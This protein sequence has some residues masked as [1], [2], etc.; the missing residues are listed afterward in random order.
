MT[1]VL[2][3]DSIADKAGTG[4]VELTKQSAAKAWCHWKQD[5]TQTIR[6]SFGISSLDDDGTGDSSLNYTSAMSDANYVNIMNGAHFIGTA[7]GSIA[8][9][10]DN[11][12]TTGSNVIRCLRVDTQA[13]YD[14]QTTQSVVHGDLA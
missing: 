4:P 5:G 13:S 11:Q 9:N 7:G 6:D 10:T 12:T 3:V 8:Y 1:S 2:N 14:S